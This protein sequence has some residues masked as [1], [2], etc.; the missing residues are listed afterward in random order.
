MDEVMFLLLIS[1]EVFM[2]LV[3]LFFYQLSQNLL[4]WED[5][6]SFMWVGEVG[7]KTL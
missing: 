5:L 4:N 3:L 6:S 1:L 2:V 7:E